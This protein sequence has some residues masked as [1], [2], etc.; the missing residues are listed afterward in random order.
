MTFYTT[1]PFFEAWF[2][3]YISIWCAEKM[4]EMWLIH[5]YDWTKFIIYTFDIVSPPIYTQCIP[6]NWSF[7]VAVNWSETTQQLTCSYISCRC[8]LPDGRSRAPPPWWAPSDRKRRR[9]QDLTRS[10][11]PQTHSGPSSPWLH[12]DAWALPT[13][14]HTVRKIQAQS[15]E[16][17]IV[18]QGNKYNKR[19]LT[20]TKYCDSTVY[21]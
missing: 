20:Q 10:S 8:V 18:I 15:R 11:A 21:E 4:S 5:L 7:V 9:C 13:D 2:V 1:K 3:L 14:L 17:R 12:T 6:A 19:Q 16:T